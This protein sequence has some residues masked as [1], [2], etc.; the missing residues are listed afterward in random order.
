MWFW[1]KEDKWQ[2]QVDL[3]TGTQE[4]G[5]NSCHRTT[6]PSSLSFC[7]FARFRIEK[8]QEWFRSSGRV[9]CFLPSRGAVRLRL[10]VC[11][12]PPPLLLPSW[13]ISNADNYTFSWVKKDPDRQEIRFSRAF[14]TRSHTGAPRVLA[15]W[16]PESCRADECDSHKTMQQFTKSFL[17]GRSSTSKRF[18]VKAGVWQPWSTPL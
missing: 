11:P 2:I 18:P 8:A 12:P 15:T 4:W 7:L 9:R 3:K 17:M 6:K 13:V 5:M 16:G 14:Q 1:A 10:P